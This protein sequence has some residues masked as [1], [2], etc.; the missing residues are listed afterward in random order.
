[1][2]CPMRAMPATAM[3]ALPHGPDLR[4]IAILGPS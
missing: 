1:M 3:S 4:E 2:T